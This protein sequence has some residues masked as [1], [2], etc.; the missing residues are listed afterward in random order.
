[1]KINCVVSS[2]GCSV[3]EVEKISLRIIVQCF[4]SFSV[5]MFSCNWV[6]ISWEIQSHIMYQINCNDLTVFYLFFIKDLSLCIMVI[7]DSEN[8]IQSSVSS[9]YCWAY[10]CY[11]TFRYWCSFFF[12]EFLL[13]LVCLQSA[14]TAIF[15]FSKN[16]WYEN[17]KNSL[18]CTNTLNP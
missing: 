2:V 1:M 3:Y 6:D 12:A 7:F 14:V 8:K 16:N 15:E 10:G 11:G 4:S 5:H 9:L 17:L 18:H 13:S